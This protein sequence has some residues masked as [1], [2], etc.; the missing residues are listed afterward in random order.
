MTLEKTMKDLWC[1][2]FLI[3]AP[4]NILCSTPLIAML[5][6]P[7]QLDLYLHLNLYMHM[8]LNLQPRNLL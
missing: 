1:F 6:F 4:S 5:W 7:G 2:Q 8:D 3:S